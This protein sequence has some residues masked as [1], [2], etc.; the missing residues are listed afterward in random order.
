MTIDATADIEVGTHLLANHPLLLQKICNIGLVR[1]S[2]LHAL[3]VKL[4]HLRTLVNCVSLNLFLP[5]YL[6][7][8]VHATL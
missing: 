3:S 8:Q 7:A 4:D 5:L 1:L 6:N 2:V